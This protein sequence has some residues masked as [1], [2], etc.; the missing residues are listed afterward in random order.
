MSRKA[1]VTDYSKWDNIEISD[2]ESD[3]HPNIEKGTWFRLKHQ[4]RVERERQ[5]AKEKKEMEE[6]NQKD[7][8]RIAE[9]A[10]LEATPELN[11]EKKKLE[12]AI[13]KAQ[14]QAGE[15]GE[16]QKVER[17]QHLPRRRGAQRGEP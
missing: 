11:D 12:E 15:D 4:Q 2:D 7:E 8:A 16:E 9:I 3:C 1:G 10:K 17:R 5:E 14:G 6:A 13:A